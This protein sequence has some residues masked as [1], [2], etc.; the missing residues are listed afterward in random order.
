MK[1]M[2]KSCCYGYD[3]HDI[4]SELFPEMVFSTQLADTQDKLDSQRT[5]NLPCPAVAF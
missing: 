4:C 3:M 5:L 2:S 1:I